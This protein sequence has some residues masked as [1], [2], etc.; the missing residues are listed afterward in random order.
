MKTPFFLVML[1]GSVLILSP[2]LGAD[3]LKSGPEVGAK[4]PGPV[5]VLA[6][7]N[8]ESPDAAEKK[9]DFVEQYGANPVVLI[10]AKTVSDPLTKLLKRVDGEVARHKMDNKKVRALLVM[11]SDDDGLE[12][13]L[14]DFAEKHGFKHVSLS[15]DSAAGPP[16]WRIAKDADVTVILYNRRKVKANHAFRKGGLNEKAIG[17]VI[18][19]LPKIVGK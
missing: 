2:S 11:L 18:A 4:L 14:K 17:T 15:I 9:W 8:A 6:L 10:F 12:E 19:D 3:E 16:R 13:K 7:V 1:G 5:H